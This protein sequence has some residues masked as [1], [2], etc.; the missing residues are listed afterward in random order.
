MLAKGPAELSIGGPDTL[1]RRDIAYLAFAALDR[2]PRLVPVGASMFGLAS[3]VAG[4]F[5]P[6]VG[7]LLEFVGRVSVT[8]SIAPATGTRRLEEYL[9]YIASERDAKPRDI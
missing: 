6:R 3:K 5:Q 1:T 8:D 4:L 9:R 2:R 7:E